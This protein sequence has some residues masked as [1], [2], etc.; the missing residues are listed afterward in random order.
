MKRLSVLALII[1]TGALFAQGA[2]PDFNAGLVALHEEQHCT[3]IA[4]FSRSVQEDP[5]NARAWYYRGLSRDASGDHAGAL[6]DLDR[7]LLLDPG[8]ANMLLRRADVLL[9]LDRPTEARRDLEQVLSRY[10]TGPIAIHALFSLGH[11]GVISG[12]HEEALAA[13]DRLLDLAPNDARA[14]CDRGIV[15]GHLQRHTDALTDLGRS[16]QLDASLQQAYVARA[17]ALIALD[18]KAD[19]CPDLVKAVELGDPS[20]QEL[21]LIY[22]DR[23]GP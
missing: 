17:L 5:G 22:C 23:Q 18:R 7:A 12:N 6:S 13:Y 4:A 9:N 2:D 10:P 20:V 16:I 21:L 15:L 14:Y 3:A 8:D 11:A 19:A 1:R